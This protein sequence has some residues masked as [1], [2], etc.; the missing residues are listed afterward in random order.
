MFKVHEDTPLVGV[1]DEP[2]EQWWRKRVEEACFSVFET[3][4]F[5]VEVV[6]APCPPVEPGGASIR[7][8]SE[9]GGIILQVLACTGAAE[10]LA[11]SLL[12]IDADDLDAELIDDAMRELAN[13]LGGVLKSHDPRGDGS[14]LLGLPKPPHPVEELEQGNYIALGLDLGDAEHMLTV[15]VQPCGGHSVLPSRVA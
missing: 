11:E 15:T 8:S 7:L 9:D 2:F 12:M 14:L 3:I 5:C 4:G 1:V 10:T 6:D 13:L